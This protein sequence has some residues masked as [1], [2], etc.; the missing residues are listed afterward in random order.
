MDHNQ[1]ITQGLDDAIDGNESYAY[2]YLQGQYFSNDIVSLSNVNGMEGLFQTIW[3]KIKQFCAWIAGLFSSK[4]EAGTT[5]KEVGLKTGLPKADKKVIKVTPVPAKKIKAAEPA[6]KAKP[7]TEEQKKSDQV[8]MKVEEF[9]AELDKAHQELKK[10]AAEEPKKVVPLIIKTQNLVVLY[11]T[12]GSISGKFA[13]HLKLARDNYEAVLKMFDELKG[14]PDSILNIM[15]LDKLEEFERR[16][17][18]PLELFKKFDKLPTNYD[19]LS[20]SQIDHIAN[21]D[22]TE[23]CREVVIAIENSK[24]T[25]MDRGWKTHS[26]EDILKY[27]EGLMKGIH[28]EADKANFGKVVI[29][30]VRLDYD[31]WALYD[32]TDALSSVKKRILDGEFF[33]R[34]P[35]V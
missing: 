17:K 35:N 13:Y 16:W 20:V 25:S 23:I 4:K 34:A 2:R 7:P 5:T 3:E 24:I 18:R 14:V 27:F 26:K 10:E 33:V 1:L 31:I 8:P 22:I 32:H 30:M 15:R 6:P 28:E 9:L 21:S 29:R 11:K 12:L 19:V